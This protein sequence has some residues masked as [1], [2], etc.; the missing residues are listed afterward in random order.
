MKRNSLCAIALCA[1]WL[2]GC[3]IFEKA[4]GSEFC[5][6]TGFLGEAQTGTFFVAGAEPAAE[7]ILSKA[8]LVDFRGSCK[9]DKGR[10]DVEMTVSLAAERGPAAA[11]VKNAGY[12][13]FSA[14][15]DRSGNILQKKLFTTVIEFDDEGHG[16]T[17]EEI[18]HLLP[19]E[20]PEAAAN[21]KIIFG[22]QLTKDELAFNREGKPL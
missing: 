7:N 1:F 14:V 21:Y 12:E 10:T 22:L 6:E 4:G 17:E 5:P 19:V 15:M 2:S 18:R 11:A 16:Q 3:T 8:A 13:W 9:F 20:K